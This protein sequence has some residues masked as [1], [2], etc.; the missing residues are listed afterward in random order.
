MKVKSFAA[1]KTIMGDN[2]I[3][4]WIALVKLRN[5]MEGF[6]AV[7]ILNTHFSAKVAAT[8]DNRDEFC[9]K[10]VRNVSFSDRPQTIL[11]QHNVPGSHWFAVIVPG[12][13]RTITAVESMGQS[14]DAILRIYKNLFDRHWFELF[15]EPSPEWIISTVRPPVSPDQR[16]N[17]NCGA[18]M[19]SVID[20]LSQVVQVGE[21]K[22]YVNGIN[23]GDF[24]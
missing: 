10:W 19:W 16:D 20:S 2:A 24:R 8:V 14:R 4:C 13:A 23:V 1:V 5:K 22:H 7:A 21:M 9:V 12:E 15:N 3:N 11:I 17:S 6:D 18:V